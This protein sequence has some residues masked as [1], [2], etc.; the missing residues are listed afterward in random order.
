MIPEMSLWF[1]S[2]DGLKLHARRYGADGAPDVVCLAGLTRNHRDFEGLARHLAAAGFR[3]TAFDSRGR[4]PS[5]RARSIEE[6]TVVAEAQDVL[7]GMTA[8]GIEHA[9]FIGT[10]RGGLIMHLLT[11]MRPAAMKA[12]LLNDIG[13]EIEPDGLLQIRTYLENAPRPAD[14]ADAIAV[15]KAVHGRAFPALTDA[16][17]VRHAHAIYRQD[18]KGRIVSDCDPLI[19]ETL[20]ALKADTPLATLWPQFDG[21]GAM[22]L[23][24][25]RGQTSRLLSERVFSQM[26]ARHAGSV[27]ITVEGQGHAPML[28]TGDLP[29]RIT[30]FLSKALK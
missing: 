11:G 14:W 17:W 12:A 8:F 18:D 1:T 28:D 25:V 30:A 20:K 29:D 2:Q 5:E 10:S 3:V 19:G 13:P 4:G 24:I 26:Q 23:M 7:A 27:A 15:Q 16:E 21:F 22:P 6:Y 9:G